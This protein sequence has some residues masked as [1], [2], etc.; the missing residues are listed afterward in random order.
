[1]L[2]RHLFLVDPSIILYPANFITLRQ[3]LAILA[4]QV[5]LYSLQTILLGSARCGISF[6]QDLFDRTPGQSRI[7]NA[8]GVRWMSYRISGW[9][10]GI[11]RHQDIGYIARHE[12]KSALLKVLRIRYN[13]LSGSTNYKFVCQSDNPVWKQSIHGAEFGSRQTTCSRSASKISLAVIPH[14]KV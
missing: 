4:G 9:T 14:K 3:I 13:K 8:V 10:A 11:F 7:S 12:E 2:A 6:Y 5:Q 1:M